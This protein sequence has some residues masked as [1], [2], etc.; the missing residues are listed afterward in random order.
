MV[1]ENHQRARITVTL[2]L[3]VYEK[4][5]ALSRQVGLLPASWVAMAATSKVNHIE[6]SMSRR[7]SA[8][9]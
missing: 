2:D 4:I 5:K 9:E 8:A 7:D 6:V 1:R 3:D